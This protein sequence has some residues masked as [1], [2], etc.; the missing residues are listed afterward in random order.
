MRSAAETARSRLEVWTERRA[1]CVDIFDD[2]MIEDW[3]LWWRVVD[4]GSRACSGIR[5]GIVGQVEVAKRSFVD[6]EL[7]WVRGNFCRM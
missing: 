3:I 4:M 2:V 5:C 7:W 6:M 1:R